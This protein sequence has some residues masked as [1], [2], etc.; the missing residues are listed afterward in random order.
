MTVATLYKDILRRFE[1]VTDITML[2]EMKNTFLADFL[3]SQK[4]GK[5]FLGIKNGAICEPNMTRKWKNANL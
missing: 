1:F 4:I 2:V 5:T 3:Q